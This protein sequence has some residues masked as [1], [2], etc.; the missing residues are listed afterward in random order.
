MFSRNL[1]PL[2]HTIVCKL[3]FSVIIHLFSRNLPLPLKS[4]AEVRCIMESILRFFRNLKSIWKTWKSHPFSIIIAWIPLSIFQYTHL[5]CRDSSLAHHPFTSQQKA[6]QPSPIQLELDSQTFIKSIVDSST[7]IHKTSFYKCFS[8][9]MTISFRPFRLMNSKAD[10][11]AK[12]NRKM[13]LEIAFQATCQV[14]TSLEEVL[15]TRLK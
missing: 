15:V 12:L 7:K 3:W 14:S 1:S 13:Q 9:R 8:L 6:F 10:L 2:T 11:W 5:K 4:I